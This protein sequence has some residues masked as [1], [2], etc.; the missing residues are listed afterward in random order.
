MKRN[1]APEYFVNT[2]SGNNSGGLGYNYSYHS[3]I[4]NPYHFL[5]FHAHEGTWQNIETVVGIF[6]VNMYD[7]GTWWLLPLFFPTTIPRGKCETDFGLACT[8]QFP[9][10]HAKDS[11]FCTVTWTSWLDVRS[12]TKLAKHKQPN[13]LPGTSKLHLLALA[14]AQGLKYRRSRWFV[15]GN[16]STQPML[17][18][19]HP[20]LKGRYIGPWNKQLEPFGMEC[21]INILKN[22]DMYVSMCFYSLEK[23]S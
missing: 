3:G 5:S 11:G 12:H 7:H 22:T 17:A 13:D 10:K 1:E 2:F 20:Q 18:T 9:M 4:L 23:T 14:W 6:F 16:N 19:L 8:G 21:N 15:A